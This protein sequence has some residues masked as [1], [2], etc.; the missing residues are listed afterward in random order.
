MSLASEWLSASQF[1]DRIAPARKHY[2]ITT[3]VEVWLYAAKTTENRQANAADYEAYCHQCAAPANLYG[4]IFHY[5]EC[6]WDIEDI[7]FRRRTASDLGLRSPLGL[8]WA[9]S[10]RN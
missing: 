4:A 9:R 7:R 8:A 3:A 1:E 5:P 10:V 2:E 6:D